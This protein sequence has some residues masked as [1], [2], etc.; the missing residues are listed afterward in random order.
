MYICG[1]I[2]IF[3]VSV[4]MTVCVLLVYLIFRA[5]HERKHAMSVKTHRMHKQLTVALILQVTKER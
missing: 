1:A 5:L 2:V 3:E 4:I